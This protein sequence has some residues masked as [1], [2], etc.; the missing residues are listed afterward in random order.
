MQPV[1][2]PLKNLPKLQEINTATQTGVICKVTNPLV[3]IIDK[4]IK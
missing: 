4:D 1:W 2:I 3:Q